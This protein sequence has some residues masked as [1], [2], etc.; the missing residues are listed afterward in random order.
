MPS[1]DV[2]LPVK[3]FTT[4]QAPSEREALCV[5]KKHV[6]ALDRTADA[7]IFVIN[8][9][10]AQTRIDHASIIVSDDEPLVEEL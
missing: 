7:Q 5:F 8:S 10:G 6:E 2:T 9:M 4:I 3:I 1:Y